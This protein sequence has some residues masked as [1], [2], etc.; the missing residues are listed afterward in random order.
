MKLTSFKISPLD[1]VLENPHII[2]ETQINVMAFAK[3]PN[4]VVLS[5]KYTNRDSESYLQALG[6]LIINF[7][8]IVP[9]GVLVFFP[10]Y[11]LLDTTS[12][13]WRRN[14][15]WKQI[16]DAK[17]IFIESK[18][19]KE[20]N[21]TV[22]KYYERVKDKKYNGAIFFAV[23]RGKVSE[24][25]DFAD[26]NGRAVIVTGLPYPLYTDPRVML[27][28]QYLDE[29]KPVEIRYK[30]LLNLDHIKRVLKK[31]K[32]SLQKIKVSNKKS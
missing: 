18:G 29:N 12:D 8:K 19:A 23:C 10:S 30:A 1:I 27:K 31:C 11:K 9:H 14:N 2:K 28:R 15:Q 16:G 22:A 7:C 3:G 13:Y 24:G 32:I 6:S 17:S 26:N 5:S 21:E 25:I 20:C 4:N